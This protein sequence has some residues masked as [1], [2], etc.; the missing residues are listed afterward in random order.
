MQL[1]F[2]RFESYRR[3]IVLSSAFNVMAN[4]AAFVSN[5]VIAYFFGA[6]AQTDIYFF[7]L[8]SLFLISGIVVSSLNTSVVIPESMTLATIGGE[9]TSMQFLNVFLYGY[10]AL[11]LLIGAAVVWQPFRIVSLLASFPSDGVHENLSTVMFAGV[12]LVLMFPC[13]HMTDILTSHRFFT[14]TA[15]LNAGNSI[16]V[17]LFV[18]AFHASLGISSAMLGL[19]TAYSVQTIVLAVMLRKALGWKFTRVGSFP[20]GRIWSN[21]AYSQTGYVASSV[22][23][24]LPLPILSSLGTGLITAY[25]LAQRVMN[26]PGTFVMNQLTSVVGIKLNSLAA[27]GDATRMNDV[28]LNTVRVTVF[29]LMPLSVLMLVFA[30]DIVV[31]L[32]RHGAFDAQAAETAAGFL[33]LFAFL[34]PLM[35]VNSM[36]SRIC[37]ALLK[38]RVV[39]AFQIAANLVLIVALVAGVRYFG[40]SWCV[41]A[42]L[43]TYVMMVLVWSLVLRRSVPEIEYGLVLKTCFQLIVINAIAGGVV[44][45]V[46][47]ALPLVEPIPRMILGGAACVLSLV[48]AVRVYRP[49]KEINAALTRAFEGLL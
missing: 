37:I 3:G 12:S 44:V 19:L 34:P 33:R 28:L 46:R 40:A 20:R 16:T 38:V 29:L 42:V 8:S 30:D 35:A 39:S 48:V 2:L 1:R 11:G 5:L 49:A 43:L 14:M 24:Y 10:A 7:C 25:G 4:G 6:H 45:G 47:Y 41:T 9:D 26:V 32:F 23:N 22:A 17:I 31:V 21:I 18:A 36:A 27:K 15:L 13:L